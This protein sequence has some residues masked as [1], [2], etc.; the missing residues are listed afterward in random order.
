MQLYFSPGACS[1]ASHIA[2]R[3]AGLSFDL[4]RTD[5]KTKKLEDGSDFFAVN[6]KGAVPALRLND[7]QVLTEG[8]AI[9][10]YIAD[11]KPDSKLA[12]KA[13][14]LERYR[15]LEWLN[16]ITS[17]VHKT[18][19]PLFNPTAADA[20]SR[21]RTSRSRSAKETVA[22]AAS[23]STWSTLRSSGLLVVIVT[24]FGVLN[25]STPGACAA[26]ASAG[27]TGTARVRRYKRSTASAI[28]ARA[29][30]TPAW[31]RS[32]RRNVRPRMKSR[33]CSVSITSWSAPRAWRVRA[34]AVVSGDGLASLRY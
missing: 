18:F 25:A 34:V 24:L 21:A 17:E 26:S 28:G 32:V 1:L 22:G 16:F 5:V 27:G 30:S 29:G 9:L 3:E 13:G 33:Y 2:L 15:L 31:H 12:P 14:T 7:G 19:S 10:Q 23:A 8:P 20:V 4:K 6:S 11:Q